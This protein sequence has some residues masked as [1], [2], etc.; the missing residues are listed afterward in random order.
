MLYEVITGPYDQGGDFRDAGMHA[1]YKWLARVW[2]TVL[3]AQ[4]GVSSD[5]EFVSQLHLV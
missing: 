5:A 3:T 2:D 1:M 4:T